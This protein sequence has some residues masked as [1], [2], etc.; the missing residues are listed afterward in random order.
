MLL[1]KIAMI[2]MLILYILVGLTAL[3]TYLV[4]I[5]E[6]RNKTEWKRKLDEEEQRKYLRDYR[7][8]QK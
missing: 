2:T 1:D 7:I 3:F 4:T 5:G 6:S 8:R